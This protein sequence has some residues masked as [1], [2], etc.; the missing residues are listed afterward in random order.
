M[1]P[2]AE[3]M[4]LRWQGEES[5][6]QLG[7]NGIL[8]VSRP[9]AMQTAW[10]EMHLAACIALENRFR[11]IDAYFGWRRRREASCGGARSSDSGG[12]KGGC[13]KLIRS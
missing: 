6:S 5:Q 13:E 3:T 12:E 2:S 9:Q 7:T 11:R 1:L 4:L 10:N 8:E